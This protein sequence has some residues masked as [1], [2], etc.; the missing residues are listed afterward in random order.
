M[1]TK[2]KGA[3]QPTKSDARRRETFMLMLIT[4]SPIPKFQKDKRFAISCISSAKKYLSKITFALRKM[5]ERLCT[6]NR[7]E[8]VHWII[9]F[10]L[11][12]GN[13]YVR[14]SS[15]MSKRKISLKRRQFNLSSNT[16][17]LIVNRQRLSDWIK[18]NVR[19]CFKRGETGKKNSARKSVEN[20]S[21]WENPYETLHQSESPN[22]LS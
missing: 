7:T 22:L 14:V 17:L 18:P 20:L 10:N 3:L 16:K 15:L 11:F 9:H 21:S 4:C 2:L 6:I 13:T 8:I 5:H 19:K 12:L 1:E